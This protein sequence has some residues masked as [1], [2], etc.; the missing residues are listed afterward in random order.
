ME[1]LKLKEL[2]LK[3]FEK[4]KD[5]IIRIG[6]DIFSHPELGFKEKRTAEIVKNFFEKCKIEFQD[7][8]A[9]TGI[10]GEIRFLDDGPNVAIFG[11]L[12]AVVSPEHPHRDPDTNAAHACG[13]NSQIANLLAAAKVLTNPALKEKLKGRVTLF[14]VPAEEYVELEYRLKLKEEGKIKY[15]GG[16]QEFIRLGLLDDVDMAMMVHA[17]DKTPQRLIGVGGTSN[18]FIGKRVIFKGKEAHAGDA[19]EKGINALNAA[20]VALNALNSIRETL[21]DEDHIRIHP[22]ITKGGDLVNIVP[23]EVIIES[24][25]RGKEID[26]IIDAAEKFDWA[27]VGGGISIGTEIHIE[28]MPGYMPLFNEPHLTEIFRENAISLV[29]K[30]HV[31]DIGHFS[32]STDMGDV[33][34]LIPSIHPVVGGYKGAAHTK[35]F[36]IADKEMAYIFPAK[37][38]VLTIIDLLSD[39]ARKAYEIKKN[40]KPKLTKEEY[41][42]TLDSFYEKKVAKRDRCIFINR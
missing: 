5:E 15:P 41:L 22:I 25:V 29:G 16:K 12:D 9:I 27:M 39:G 23:H 42:K 10:Q 2:V 37:L 13:H 36:T 38:Y 1:L 24:Y 31:F 34:Q 19:P 11:E 30:E 40:W 4:I 8:I 35:E 6:D 20:Q 21:K 26:A 32:A 17:K 7:G 18:G 33:S 14:A 3:D 28:N